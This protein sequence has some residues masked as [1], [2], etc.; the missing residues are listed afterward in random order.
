MT[1]AIDFMPPEEAE[2]TSD[3]ATAGAAEPSA[4]WVTVNARGRKASAG[5][6]AASADGAEEPLAPGG[7]PGGQPST[8]WGWEREA[9]AEARSAA[10]LAE[11][12]SREATARDIA[13]EAAELQEVLERSEREARTLALAQEAREREAKERE[14][15]EREAR[16]REARRGE[17]TTQRRRGV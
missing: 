10:A 9:E 5:G 13:R 6:G 14:A 1:V 8:T 16:E 2:P 11:R 3:G 4:E 15:R 12:L 7:V 17:A